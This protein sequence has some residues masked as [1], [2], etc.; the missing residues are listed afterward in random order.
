MQV[1]VWRC[2]HAMFCVEILMRKIYHTHLCLYI[3]DTCNFIFTH[4]YL[5]KD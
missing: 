2:E 3:N 4:Q 1:C 5:R